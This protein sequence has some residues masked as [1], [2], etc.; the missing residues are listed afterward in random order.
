MADYE[1]RWMW[2]P[3]LK[4]QDCSGWKEEC[5]AE[6]LNHLKRSSHK[7]RRDV[8]VLL[9]PLGLLGWVASPSSKSGGT[10][11]PGGFRKET[12]DITNPD[13]GLICNNYECL[14]SA[15]RDLT[16]SSARP[17]EGVHKS[18]RGSTAGDCRPGL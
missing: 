18:A 9:K 17:W 13:E 3:K 8:R 16:D 4:S 12:N 2:V 14:R 1:G 7:R 11:L 6:T 5:L 15:S 10:S